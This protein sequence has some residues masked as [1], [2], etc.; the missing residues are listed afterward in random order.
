MEQ[1]VAPL[2]YTGSS[3]RCYKLGLLDAEDGTK[4]SLNFSNKS[5]DVAVHGYKYEMKYHHLKNKYVTHLWMINAT[6]SLMDWDQIS[7]SP[8]VAPKSMTDWDLRTQ[9]Y[10]VQIH[11]QQESMLD[12]WLAIIIIWSHY[13]CS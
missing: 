3:Q 6:H 11:A 5:P 1:T 4:I 13:S 9:D 10:E 7:S 8:R 12:I 2:I